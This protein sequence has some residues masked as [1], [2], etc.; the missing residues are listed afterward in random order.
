MKIGSDP[1]QRDPILVFRKCPDQA[2]HDVLQRI[3]HMLYFETIVI[4]LS[5][6]IYG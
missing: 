2:S 4:I 5:E 1:S 3:L 6:E